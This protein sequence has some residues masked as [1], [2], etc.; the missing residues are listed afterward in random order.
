[1]AVEPPLVEPSGSKATK[2]D[3][4]GVGVGTGVGDG[5]AV[6]CAVGLDDGEAVG[7]GVAVGA[8][9]GVAV[10]VADGFAEGEA[11]VGVEG[12]GQPPGDAVGPEVVHDVGVEVDVEVEDEDE[13]GVAVGDG[14]ADEIG[15]A[16][17]AAPAPGAHGE[18]LSAGRTGES[19]GALDW[20]D[21]SLGVVSADIA[22]PVPPA[23]SAAVAPSMASVVGGA[24]IW[25]PGDPV[26]P[27]PAEFEVPSSAATTATAARPPM[28]AGSGTP[29]RCVA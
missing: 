28:R 23:T 29:R 14:A 6:G 26:G 15:D 19:S 18:P 24:A 27:D 16:A 17:P 4:A 12:S 5:V 25:W 8:A 22:D 3:G 7:R 1:M 13:A 21:P 2:S 20:T 10:V 9:V 11:E